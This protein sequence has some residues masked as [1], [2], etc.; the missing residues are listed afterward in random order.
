M[1]KGNATW[2]MTCSASG[3]VNCLRSRRPVQILLGSCGSQHSI[4]ACVKTLLRAAP[5]FLP[6]EFWEV[7][8]W[9]LAKFDGADLSDANLYDAEGLTQTQL[10]LAQLSSGT[11]LPDGLTG[12]EDAKG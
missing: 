2:D 10:D 9:R 5:V 11:K 7:R 4:Q 1:I 8:S 6:N 12:A 3:A